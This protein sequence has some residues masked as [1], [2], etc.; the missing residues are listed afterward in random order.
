MITAVAIVDELAKGL[1]M[2]TG[3]GE[4]EAAWWSAIT[5]VKGMEAV[6]WQSA[7]TDA[8]ETDGVVGWLETALFETMDTNIEDQYATCL[9]ACRAGPTSLSAW[10]F[11]SSCDM[12]LIKL[13]KGRWFDAPTAVLWMSTARSS[14][15]AV[16]ISSL[17]FMM[18]LAEGMFLDKRSEMWSLT[19]IASTAF[20]R[21]D[22]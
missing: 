1:E 2:Q 5:A 22:S 9:A 6:G 18:H 7:I 21:S 16:R 3:A 4:T 20:E 12:L 15:K 8:V 11:S 10:K 17:S 13:T 19:L 14:C